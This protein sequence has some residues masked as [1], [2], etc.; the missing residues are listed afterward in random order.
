M[1]FKGNEGQV[2]VN[3]ELKL[4]VGIAPMSVLAVNPSLDELQT[5]LGINFQNELQYITD[6]VDENT[7]AQYRNIRLDFWLGNEQ[8]GI[9]TKVSFFID[10]RDNLNKAGTTKEYINA[11]GRTVKAQVTNPDFSGFKWFQQVGVRPSKPGEDDLIRFI[12]AFLNIGP[13]DEA[14]IEDWK[15]IFNGDISE[16]KKLV[17]HYGKTNTLK[18]MLMVTNK[19]GKYFQSVYPGYFAVW[20]STS[21][22]AWKDHIEKYDSTNDRYWN[23][24]KGEYSYQLKEFIIPVA[25]PQPSDEEGV[26]PIP[27]GVIPPPAGTGFF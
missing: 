20:N 1:A 4:W 22:K 24:P 10:D 9:K 2:V 18:V 27:E 7:Q 3:R 12:R 23:K 16:I 13:K 25:D 15:S 11:F 14:V 21:L 17:A 26:A 5:N 8:L 19:D 6:K